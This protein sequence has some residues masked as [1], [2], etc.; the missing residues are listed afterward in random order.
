MCDGY[1]LTK[2]PPEVTRKVRKGIESWRNMGYLLEA[3]QTPAPLIARPVMR[4][5]V[6]PL[7]VALLLKSARELR[8]RRWVSRST[9]GV[10]SRRIVLEK[11]S[12]V[13]S[14]LLLLGKNLHVDGGC[15][16]AR[17]TWAMGYRADS[18]VGAWAT[19]GCNKAIGAAFATK[20]A[21]VEIGW[22]AM[23]VGE[24]KVGE[25]R[26]SLVNKYA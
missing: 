16:G 12:L 1:V 15:D 9:S 20:W 7:T 6:P 8:V 26:E 10:P 14:L 18:I 23:N 17:K 3:N 19:E 11:H 21:M 13:V 4:P 25:R 24:R 5:T 2:V 22:M